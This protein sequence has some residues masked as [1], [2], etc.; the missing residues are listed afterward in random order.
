MKNFFR[1]MKKNEV[2]RR[3]RNILRVSVAVIL[4]VLLLASSGVHSTI[5]KDIFNTYTNIRLGVAYLNDLAGQ[6]TSLEEVAMAHNAGPGAVRRGFR[7]ESYW[8]KIRTSYSE[9]SHDF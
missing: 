4:P 5:Q 2:A 9:I 7:P 8:E 1:K 3:K 6:M